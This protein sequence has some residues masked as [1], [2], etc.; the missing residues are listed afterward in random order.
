MLLWHYY[1]MINT[2]KRNL[3]YVYFVKQLYIWLGTIVQ[4]IDLS[5]ERE[6]CSKRQCRLKYALPTL[7]VE[8]KY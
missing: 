8:C 5:I 1:V 7:I 6:Y 2:N 3:K 4:S